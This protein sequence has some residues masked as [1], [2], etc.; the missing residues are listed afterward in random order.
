M[1][2]TMLATKKSEIS[3]GLRPVNVRTD[4]AQLADLMEITFHDTMDESGRAAIRERDGRRLVRSRV[5][6]R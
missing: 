2:G 3:Q 1:T 4:L 5:Y 6:D